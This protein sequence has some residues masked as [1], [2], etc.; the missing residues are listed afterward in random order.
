MS[1]DDDRIWPVIYSIDLFQSTIDIFVITDQTLA[2][3]KI[4]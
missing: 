3:L 1:I 4:L 2:T